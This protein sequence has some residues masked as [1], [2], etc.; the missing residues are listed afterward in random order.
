MKRFSFPLFLFFNTLVFAATNYYS[1][2][3]L[4]A[5]LTSSWKSSLN[6]QPSS[7][8][9]GDVFI[10]QSGHT[11]STTAPWTVSGTNAEIILNGGSLTFAHNSVTQRL[12]ITVGDV[13]VNTGV[14]VTI[15]NGN[16]IGGGMI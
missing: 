11:M 14:T 4:P 9:L 16:T 2:G 12:T 10:I 1:Q 3:S 5:N 13:T 7:F 8:T 15:N 6:A